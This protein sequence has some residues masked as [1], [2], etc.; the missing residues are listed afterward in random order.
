MS[1]ADFLKRKYKLGMGKE[2]L[3]KEYRADFVVQERFEQS[4]YMA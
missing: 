1:D 2:Y 3:D 4:D